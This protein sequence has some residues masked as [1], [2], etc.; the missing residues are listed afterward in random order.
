LIVVTETVQA[1]AHRLHSRLD[2]IRSSGTIPEFISAA[3][4]WGVLPVLSR[5]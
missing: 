3:F 1:E 2:L 5:R 4:D